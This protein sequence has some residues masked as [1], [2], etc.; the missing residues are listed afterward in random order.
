MTPLPISDVVYAQT[1]EVFTQKTQSNHLK[2]LN[3]TQSKSNYEIFSHLTTTIILRCFD[4]YK[5]EFF[6]QALV[7]L[8]QNTSRTS[9][10]RVI[11]TYRNRTLRTTLITHLYFWR[12]WVSLWYRAY[13]AQWTMCLSSMGLVRALCGHYA[14]KTQRSLHKKNQVITM[15]NYPVMGTK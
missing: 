15:N 7:T 13:F 1:W 5:N 10:L 6:L 3:V 9:V 11:R 14:R 12:L 8:S 2:Y 4:L